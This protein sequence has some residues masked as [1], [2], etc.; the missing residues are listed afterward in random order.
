MSESGLGGS[1]S[2]V[3]VN[4]GRVER[5]GDGYKVIQD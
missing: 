2:E 3:E 4:G 5:D 1:V